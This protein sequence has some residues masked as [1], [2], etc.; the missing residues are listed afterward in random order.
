MTTASVVTDA[1]GG[2]SSQLLRDLTNQGASTSIDSTVL[3]SAVSMA[4]GRFRVL[5]GV[6]PDSSLDW[7]VAPLIAGTLWALEALKRRDSN[8][9]KVSADAF[10]YACEEIR[11]KAAI[12][13]STSSELEPSTE[14]AGAKP[15]MDRQGA[16]I[17]GLTDGV[18][19]S[20]GIT[21][22]S[23]ST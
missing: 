5:T 15:D 22:Y 19:R 16:L 10:R 2:A 14:T 1:L 17:K 21:D 18:S 11:N 13:V 20:G 3:A 8:M 23:P 12:S 9:I 6:A 7:H 4:E